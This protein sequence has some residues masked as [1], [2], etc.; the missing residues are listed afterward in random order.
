MP[1][2]CIPA[3]M[4]CIILDLAYAKFLHQACNSFFLYT[5]IIWI[6]PLHSILTE[7]TFFDYLIFFHSLMCEYTIGLVN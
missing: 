5:S 6:T 1:K 2:F 4:D 7:A 3:S